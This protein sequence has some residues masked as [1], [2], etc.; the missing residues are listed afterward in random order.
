MANQHDKHPLDAV[1]LTKRQSEHHRQ[2]IRVGVILHRLQAC[3]E[4][5]LE[6]RPTELQAA[7]LLVDKAIPNLQAVAISE[8]TP[9]EALLSE[10]QIIDNLVERLEAMPE[11]RQAVLDQLLPLITADGS[12]DSEDDGSIH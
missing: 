11:V 8:E 7:K 6:M 2:S 4:G 1:K 12:S 9:P 5:T 10:Q 3:V